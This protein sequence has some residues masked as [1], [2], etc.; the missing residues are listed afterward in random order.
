M[1]SFI[2]ENGRT[3]VPLRAVVEALGAEVDLNEDERKIT[4]SYDGDEI[5]M[6]VGETTAY[7][8]GEEVTLEAAPKIRGGRTVVPVRFIAE[9]FGLT[10]TWDAESGTIII[11]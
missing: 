4:L 9:T 6:T 5:E 1:K 8:N 11:E 2:D 7:V 10:V 3:L